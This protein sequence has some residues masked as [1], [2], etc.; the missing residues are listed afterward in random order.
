MRIISGKFGGQTIKPPKGHKT[1]PM[2]EK[3]RGALFNALGD[4]EG[5]TVLDAFAGSGAIGIEAISRGAKFALM[6]DE[7]KQAQL[8]IAD[9]IKATQVTKQTKLVKASANA[10]LSTTNDQFDL[11][12]LDPPFEK[13]QKPLLKQLSER[14]KPG[15]LAIFSLPPNEFVDL[16]ECFENLQTKKYGDNQLVFYRRIK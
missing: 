9:N 16:D 11:V 6:I 14:T 1:H 13:L 15:G 8:A 3:G 12:V 7:S 2:N 10:W 5:L 4:I